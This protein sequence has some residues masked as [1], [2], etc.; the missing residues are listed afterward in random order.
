MKIEKQFEGQPRACRS[1]QPAVHPN[2]RGEH[3]LGSR[4]RI[5]SRGSSPRAWGTHFFLLAEFTTIFW[6]LKFHHLICRNPATKC[7]CILRIS[8]KYFHVF[9]KN[10]SVIKWQ[11]RYKLGAVH[12]YWYPPICTQ[13][14]K[15]EASLIIG[16]P[17][18]HRITFLDPVLDLL[19]D[20]ITNLGGIVTHINASAYFQ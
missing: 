11:E 20:K 8:L 18:H 12:F 7:Y 4:A 17:S 9:L 16:A 10:R 13:G 2:G 19:P 3:R 6:Y 15:V 14:H 5:H 1:L